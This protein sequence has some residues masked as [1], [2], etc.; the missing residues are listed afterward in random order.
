V[1]AWTV[2][3]RACKV[4]ALS[5]VAKLARKRFVDMFVVKILLVITLWA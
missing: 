3:V 5:N 1:D 2:D 4:F